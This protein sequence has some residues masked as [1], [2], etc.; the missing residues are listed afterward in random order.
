MLSGSRRRRKI[1][2]FLFPNTSINRMKQVPGVF[3]VPQTSLVHQGLQVGYLLWAQSRLITVPWFSS[4][5]NSPVHGSKQ[6]SRVIWVTISSLSIE[7]L[8]ILELDEEKADNAEYYR[9]CPLHGALTEDC[10]SLEPAARPWEPA[11]LPGQI[12]NWNKII[13]FLNI[14]FNQ[15]ISKIDRLIFYVLCSYWIQSRRFN[16]RIFYLFA[17]YDLAGRLSPTLVFISLSLMGNIITSLITL[18]TRQAILL[19]KFCLY[20]RHVYHPLDYTISIWG[21]EYSKRR[22]N[23]NI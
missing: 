15:N 9:S 10:E 14:C 8:A 11:G 5:V 19:H 12:R 20:T 23:L 16:L 1:F 21:M 22:M 13:W 4:L 3:R 6:V 7:R 2:L 17:S 18:Q